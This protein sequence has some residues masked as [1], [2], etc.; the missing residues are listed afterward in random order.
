MYAD[1][2]SLRYWKSE[3]AGIATCEDALRYKVQHGLFC[4]ADGAGTTLFSNIWADILVERFVQDPLMSNDPF[5]MEWWI[6]QAQKYYR[7]QAPKSDKL[8]WNARQKALEQGAYST[9]ATLRFTHCDTQAATAELLVVG[10]SCVIIGHQEQV[11]AFPLQHTE[12][13]DRAPYCV[14]ALLKNLN[15]YTLYAKTR[16][17]TLIPGDIVILATDAVARWIISG[18]GTGKEE[19]AYQALLEVAKKTEDDWP[20]FIDN[21]RAKQ[22]IVDDDST[23]IIIHLQEA[24]RDE[25]RLGM[26]EWPLP[27]MVALRKAEFE[28]A[29]SGDNKELVAITYGDGRMLNAAGVSLPDNESKLAR[30]V[31]DALRDLLQ[32]MRDALNSPSFV[33]KVEPVWWRYADLLMEEPCAENIRKSLVAQGVRLKRPPNPPLP[34]RSPQ[35]GQQTPAPGNPPLT[36]QPDAT[37]KD[38]NSGLR[39]G[40]T[41]LQRLT[42]TEPELAR[43]IT[44]TLSSPGVA[45]FQALLP[46]FREA[47]TTNDP[48]TIVNA[49]HPSF[50]SDLTTEERALLKEARTNLMYDLTNRLR[51]ALDQNDDATILDIAMSIESSPV[52]IDLTES[53]KHRIQQARERNAA[54]EHLLTFL[55]EGT[56]QQKL[57]V[58]IP[59][60]QI[61]K[62]LTPAQ[63]DQLDI[64]RRLV[65]ALH[66]NDSD[67]ICSVY[68]T[69]EF[70]PI[71][72]HFLFTPDDQR[73]IQQARENQAAVQQFRMILQSGRA[74]LA[75]LMYAYQ[76]IDTP[77]SYLT[78]NERHIIE[79]AQR[80]LQYPQDDQQTVLLKSEEQ[81]VQFYGELYYSP[82]KFSF[83]EDEAREAARARNH[84]GRYTPAVVVVNHDPV[85]INQFLDLY[86]VKPFYAHSQI[87]VYRRRLEANP[88]DQERQQLEHKIAFWKHQLEPQYLPAIVLDNLVNQVLL[89]QKMEEEISRDKS[90]RFLEKDVQKKLDEIF[91]EFR[92]IPAKDLQALLT[93]ISE[94]DIRKALKPYALYFVFDRYLQ[95]AS[96]EHTLTIWL[97]E[98]RK[99]SVIHYYEEPVEHAPI[100][101]KQQ[102][103]WLF[104]WWFIRDSYNMPLQQGETEYA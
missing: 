66:S 70:S 53:E 33:A 86:Y 68:E 96:S 35:S 85:H 77:K 2:T 49:Y 65:D 78:L 101:T 75:L 88:S 39:Q 99:T 27:D 28:H 54:F 7:E 6:R 25:E 26:P 10:D 40:E 46:V 103:C 58:G 97:N 104:K 22:L 42:G 50:D 93:H 52:K 61:Q 92:N 23:A 76:F 73:R 69:I 24:G 31:A 79:V 72:K 56:A 19:M 64:A 16:E 62:L 51:T 11:I 98:Q 47:L 8:N 55:E 1:V 21:C 45:Q 5:E 90:K 84:A 87:S 41:S 48:F 34:T 82:Y 102:D 3:R 81:L 20:N 91:K 57:E 36:S 80:L 83:T 59:L 67:M 44:P 100:T 74:T 38:S 29:R 12:D 89:E 18:G 71:R 60:S 32:T 95:A 94:Q 63:Q 43:V 4:V 14:P 9:L 37:T 17:V 30:Q 13:F 15:R